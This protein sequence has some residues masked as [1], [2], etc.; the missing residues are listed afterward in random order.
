[1]TQGEAGFI[2]GYD[3]GLMEMGHGVESWMSKMVMP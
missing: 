3:L 2:G 1:M